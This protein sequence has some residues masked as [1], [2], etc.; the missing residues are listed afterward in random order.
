MIIFMKKIL[1]STAAIAYMFSAA[2]CQRDTIE[3]AAQEGEVV[4]ATLTIQTPGQLGT[5]AATSDEQEMIG[6]GR[7]ADNLVFAVFDEDGN[8]L[9]DLRQGDWVNSIGENR[10]EIVFN[11]DAAP[12]T[13]VTVKLVRGKEYT[14][15]CWAQNK[16]AECYDFEDMKNIGISYEQYNVSNNDLR[17]AFYASVKTGKV[18]E[19]FSKNITLKRPFAQINVGTTDMVE[20][21]KAGLEGGNLYST[22]TVKN[23]ATVL[24]TFTGAASEAKEVTFEYGHIVAPD[25]KLVIDRDKVVN[26]PSAAIADQYDWLAMNYILVADDTADGASSALAEVSFAVRENDAAVLTTYEV[27]NVPVQRNHRTNIVGGLLTADGEICIIIDPLF[28]GEYV[29]GGYSL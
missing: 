21:M 2:S 15:V 28:V 1:L 9:T 19:N 20:A 17:D 5:K 14:F 11:N 24:N 7:A 25:Y 6:D 4:T 10:S 18:T 12:T 13:T 23:A 22:M 3:P 27:S 8:E 26:N 29:V 16:A